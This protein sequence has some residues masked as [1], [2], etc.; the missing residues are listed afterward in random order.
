MSIFT[1]WALWCWICLWSLGIFYTNFTSNLLHYYWGVSVE[2][3]GGVQ[4]FEELSN[5]LISLTSWWC[6]SCI[7]LG[8][9]GNVKVWGK[10]MCTD[11]RMILEISVS[12]EEYLNFLSSILGKM[13]PWLAFKPLYIIKI[14]FIFSH[15]A[16]KNV[17]I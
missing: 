17:T 8:A 4:N 6:E 9:S 10:V 7:E 13:Q 5:W 15:R 12:E 1:R 11:S 3:F 2:K 14:K 16:P